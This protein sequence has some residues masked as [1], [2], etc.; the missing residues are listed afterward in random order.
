MAD[1]KSIPTQENK[2]KFG[3]KTRRI[4]KT[5]L[6]LGPLAVAATASYL[7]WTD[8]RV[9]STDNAYVQADKV[10]ISAEVAGQINDVRVQENERVEKGTP[11]FAID[12]R[13]YE[14]MLKEAKAHR[15][16]VL[17]AIRTTKASY[18]QKLSELK[19]AKN[20]I[21]FAKNE[22]KRQYILNSQK[23]SPKAQL[24]SAQHD[25]D[26]SNYKLA[27]TKTEA[28]QILAAL[29]GDPDIDEKLVASYR[30][31]QAEVERAALNLERTVV[32]APFSGRVS[33]IPQVGMHVEPGSAV[34]TLIADQ[35]F[36]VEANLKETDLTH[37]HKGQHVTINIDTYPDVQ[38][39]GIVQSISPAA[40]SEYA[41]I[42]AQNATGNWVKVVQRIPVRI[43]VS[44][45][46]DTP[47]L[48]AGMS[49][50]VKVDTGYQ[51]KLPDLVHTLLGAIGLAEDAQAKTK[52]R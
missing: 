5:L 10:L 13:S 19:L 12:G 22:F 34:M 47:L 51:R 41:I 40:G 15:Q 24:D 11:L 8:G 31:A 27:I 25:L 30:L 32:R 6:L 17:A 50:I 23:A 7:Y 43:Q 38:F 37:V 28:E 42:P 46:N 21:D 33:K 26:V 9:I 16:E 4:R 3:S 45:K 36:W 18:R 20:N 44:E 35:D 49:A 52:I 1:D 14:I 48:R 2:R 39:D 29:E